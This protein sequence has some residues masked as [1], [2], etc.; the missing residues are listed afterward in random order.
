MKKLILCEAELSLEVIE[1]G[2]E[3]Q[4]SGWRICSPFLSP[5][6]GYWGFPG[7]GQSSMDQAKV[8]VYT[9]E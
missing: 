7:W 1:P 6:S 2:F 9:T 3:P 8:G 4:N 5:D